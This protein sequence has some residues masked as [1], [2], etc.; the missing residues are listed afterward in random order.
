MPSTLNPLT[1][2]TKKQYAQPTHLSVFILIIRITTNNYNRLLSYF[3][4]PINF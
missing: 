1:G 3:D 2:H 4:R